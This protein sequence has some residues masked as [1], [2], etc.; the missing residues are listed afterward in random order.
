MWIA[1]LPK[2]L[3]GHPSESMMSSCGET[4]DHHSHNNDREHDAACNNVRLY[5]LHKNKCK[6]HVKFKK[7]ETAIKKPAHHYE[8]RDS[9][10]CHDLSVKMIADILIYYYCHNYRLTITSFVVSVATGLLL[11]VS[12][13]LRPWHNHIADHVFHAEDQGSNQLVQASLLILQGQAVTVFGTKKP[14]SSLLD[15]RLLFNNI[16]K[17]ILQRQVGNAAFVST[18]QLWL[19]K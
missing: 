6:F 12:Y 2:R 18:F 10:Y 11:L 13:L 16:S 8:H 19:T 17:V 7:D 14:F 15:L 3:H 9:C 4:H 1:S 5:T